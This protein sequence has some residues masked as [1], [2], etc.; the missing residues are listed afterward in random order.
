[1]PTRSAKILKKDAN[2]S[3]KANFLTTNKKFFFFP[4]SFNFFQNKSC[5]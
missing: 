4:A 3:K 2:V 5:H 1:M